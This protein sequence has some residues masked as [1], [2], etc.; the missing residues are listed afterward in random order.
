MNLLRHAV[1]PLADGRP[2]FA[3]VVETGGH[4]A[5]LEALLDDRADVAAIDCVTFAFVLDHLPQ[6]ARGVVEI[7]IDAESPG[8]PLIASKRVPPD[9][10]E[11]L[12]SAL[13]RR[14][15]PRS[16]AGKTAQARRLHRSVRSTTTPAFSTSKPTP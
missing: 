15:R 12:R 7:G 6:L 5:S 11:A 1:A 3:S 2:F 13:D 4:L 8:L 10:I 9:G 16:T 14:R